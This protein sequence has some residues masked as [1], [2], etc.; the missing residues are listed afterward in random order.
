MS[1]TKNGNG[2]AHAH[3]RPAIVK[4]LAMFTFQLIATTSAKNDVAGY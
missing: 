3:Q 2:I 4:K 1:T